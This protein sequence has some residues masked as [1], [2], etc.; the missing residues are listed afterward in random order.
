MFISASHD[1]TYNTLTP[2]N[3]ATLMLASHFPTIQLDS[4]QQR[5]LKQ[6]PVL[7]GCHLSGAKV[8]SNKNKEPSTSGGGVL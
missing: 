2:H 4:Q 6:T 5:L 7:E 1:T 3:T 8:S